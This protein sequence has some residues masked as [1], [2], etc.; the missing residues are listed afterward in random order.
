MGLVRKLWNFLNKPIGFF[1]IRRVEEYRKVRRELRE[2]E[3]DYEILARD[4]ESEVRKNSKISQDQHS[5]LINFMRLREKAHELE[6]SAK[7][8]ETVRNQ[9]KIGILHVDK[10]YKLIDVNETACRYLDLEIEDL[11]PDL[12]EVAS[13]EDYLQGYFKFFKAQSQ[14]IKV[15]G[16]RLKE[17]VF[18]IGDVGFDVQGFYI[19]SDDP[20]EYKGGFIL[21]TPYKE[22]SVLEQIFG[23]R[24]V[25]I[26]PKEP[27]VKERFELLC[28]LVEKVKYKEV[29]LTNSSAN[30]AALKHLAD[31]YKCFKGDGRFVFRGLSKSEKDYLIRA[32]I[33]EEDILSIRKTETQSKEETG[34]YPAIQGTGA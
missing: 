24:K 31:H 30:E 33:V 26:A 23:K 9:S 22:R 5:L 16:D 19:P 15:V 2:L 29:D 3:E 11:S 13:N 18:K 14:R 28:P 25:V 12:E 21:I 32:G 1:N 8:G 27:L 6:E 20:E 34:Q 4:L 7:L 10:N 17:C